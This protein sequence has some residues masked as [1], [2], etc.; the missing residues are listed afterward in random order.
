MFKKLLKIYQLRS[1]LEKD[2]TVEK[3][4]FENNIALKKAQL[5][6]LVEQESLLREQAFLIL[7][8]KKLDSIK[9]GDYTIWRQVKKTYQIRDVYQLKS[10]I[11]YNWKEIEK[12]YKDIDLGNI[13]EE[14]TVIKDKEI[15]NDIIDKWEKIEGKL[16]GGVG[17]KETKFVVI[18]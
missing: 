3:Q 17:V 10:S 4:E 8:E 2:I 7:E 11:V 14:Q 18:K 12:L 6:D 9:E 1:A 15:V 13:F 16:L 5:I